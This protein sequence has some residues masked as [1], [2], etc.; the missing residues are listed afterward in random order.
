M[1]MG[2][3]KIYEVKERLNPLKETLSDVIHS[4]MVEAF[5]FPSDKKFHPFFPLEK[6]DFYFVSGRTE[7]YTII[8]V[9][10]KKL[11]NSL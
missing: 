9:E 1:R 8:E 11:K 5:K 10:P 6:E 3:I 2:Q 4:C 7:A